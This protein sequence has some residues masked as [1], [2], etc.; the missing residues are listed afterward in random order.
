MRVKDTRIVA[1]SF[2]RFRAM[3]RVRLNRLDLGRGNFVTFWN[4]EVMM[5]IQESWVSL[6][7]PR[8]SLFASTQYLD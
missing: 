7:P 3:S 1:D 4:M 6:G 8:E 2:S 5:L